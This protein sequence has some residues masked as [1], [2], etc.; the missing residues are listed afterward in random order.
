MATADALLDPLGIPGQVV[1]DDQGAEL[2]IDALGAGFGGDHD[3]RFL[4]E[5]IH[6]RRPHVGGFRAGDP[7]RALMPVQPVLINLPGS[8]VRI[9][10][11]EKN[12]LASEF[13]SLQD[14]SQ[15][16]LGAGGFGK[17][18]RLFL[19][20]LGFGLRSLTANAVSRTSPL[21]FFRMDLARSLNSR[22]ER[23]SFMAAI[24]CGVRGVV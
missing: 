10:T 9:R 20:A 19:A 12:D 5:I 23:I 8:L 4:L 16:F 3:G 13:S 18:E 11:V 6:E 17:D 15:I 24:S 14:F 21:E 7:V 22:R 2:E 1:V